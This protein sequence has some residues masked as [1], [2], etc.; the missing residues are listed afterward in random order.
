MLFRAR[1]GRNFGLSLGL[2]VCRAVSS[3][4]SA[5]KQGDWGGTFSVFLMLVSAPFLVGQQIEPGCV[6]SVVVRVASVV[7]P[8][9]DVVSVLP[10]RCV[11][12]VWL[13]RRV[14]AFARLK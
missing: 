5:G 11:V 1:S 7:G 14:H 10:S 9:H 8:P 6:G 4:S 13:A 2:L 3:A 12:G